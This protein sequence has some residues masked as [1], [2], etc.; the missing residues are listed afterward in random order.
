MGLT[1]HDAMS[2][3][4]LPELPP[5]AWTDWARLYRNAVGLST[6]A[7][8][9]FHYVALLTVV[10]A[11][12]GRSVTVLCGRPV[13][14]NVYAM[15]IGPTG[16][17]KSTAADLAL[18]LL[19]EVAP[20]VLLLNGVGSQEGLMERMAEA[21]PASGRQRRTLL[22]IDEVAALLKKSR[23]E[24]SGSLLEFITEVFHCPDFKT[25]A[26]RSKGIHLEYPTL[27]ILACSTPAWLEAALEEEDI[28][29]GFANR[30]VYVTGPPKP[31]TPL[32]PPPDQ[33]AL[34]HLTEWIRRVAQKPVRQ[35]G[36]TPP[37]ERLWSEFYLE[38]RRALNQLGDH[39]SA[40]L[41]RTDIYI[42]K[43][44]CLAAA[45]DDAHQITLAHLGPAIDLGRYLAGCTLQLLGELGAPRD[46]RLERIV[47]QKLT[48]AQ[49]Q[50]RRKQL[51][52][53]L[54]GRVS[55]EKLDRI[56]SAME[57]NGII[58]QIDDT[59]SRGTKIVQLT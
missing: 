11:V 36:W 29:G 38:W 19:S 24:S 45:M 26:T 17:R 42:L 59:H 33:C 49:G 37:A 2:G 47:E 32:P 1:A 4:L 16:D 22:A 23:R 55:G 58:R 20:E 43:F 27:S 41:R 28:L 52:Q 8:D 10:G 34:T 57:R 3:L 50:M 21:D 13:H 53:A 18:A 30:F 46:C 31:D 39:A 48:A 54:G 25:H 12:L 5:S 40:L 14:V 35:L 56:L 15:L 44:A 6:E 51:R 9:V 7:A